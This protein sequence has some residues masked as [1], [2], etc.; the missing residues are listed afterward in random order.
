MVVSP[1]GRGCEGQGSWVFPDL[2][3]VQVRLPLEQTPLSLAR[4]Q[5]PRPEQAP[6]L[7]EELGRAME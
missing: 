1:G 2:R 7:G 5:G 3:L 6:R 4:S